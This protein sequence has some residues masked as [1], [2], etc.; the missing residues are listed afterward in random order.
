MPE[1]IKDTEC[2][3]DTPVIWGKLSDRS[4]GTGKRIKPNI[5]GKHATDYEKKIYLPELLPL[6]EYDLVIVLFSGGK[7]STAAYFK[8]LE[9]GV[10]KNKI[11]LWH[12][13]IDG[14]N[15]ER[16]MDWPCTQEYVKAFAEREKVTLRVSWR[17]QGLCLPCSSRGDPAD[18]KRKIYSRRNYHPVRALGLSCGSVQRQRRRSMLGGHRM[19]LT[20]ICSPCRGDYEKNII[21]AQEYCREAM[22]DGLLP[23]AP[24]VYFTQFVDDT[25]PEERK[26]GL[27]CGLQLLRHCQLI[28]VYGCKVSAGMYDE[29]QLAG[30]LDIEIQVFGPPEF[31][32][33][34]LEIYNHAA[35]TQRRPL[36]KHAVS[37]AA[38]YADQP[39]A[40]PL[41]TEAGKSLREVTA[42][43]INID[44]TEA[45]ELGEMIAS[46]LR[47]GSSMLRGGA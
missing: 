2:S 43:H 16:R 29:I 24:H 19:K 36:R 40:A 1:Y 22:N 41:L 32:E 12:H 34:V 33:N 38:A 17:D 37:A 45:S 47:N 25:N 15:K 44:P 39:A 14:K 6:E 11:E 3:R 5:D 9:L 35:V 30:V 42:V 28:R 7:D 26:L 10:P 21:K 46:S 31:I 23:L 18:Y 13:D 4:Y 8:L 20:Y 27:R